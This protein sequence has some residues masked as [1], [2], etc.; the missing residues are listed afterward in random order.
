MRYKEPYCLFKKRLES[1][2]FV[3]YYSYYDPMGRRKQ[4][5]MGCRLKSEAKKYCLE[6]YRRG[7]MEPP[8]D[9]TFREYTRDFSIY[10]KCCYPGPGAAE[11]DG[12]KE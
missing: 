6:L 5:S 9:V 1:G 4:L 11:P 12:G 2:R 10:D 7:P 8:E 3:Y